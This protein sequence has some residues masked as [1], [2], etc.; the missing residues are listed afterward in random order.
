[1]I[2]TLDQQIEAMAND[3]PNLAMVRRSPSG[4]SCIWKGSIRPFRKTY[5]LEVFYHAPI[6]PEVFTISGCQLLVQVR[7]PTLERHPDYDEGPI[8]HI[9]ANDE[10]PAYPYL[11]LFDPFKPEWTP[12][13]LISATTIPWAERWL[14]NYE[15]WLATKLWKGGGRHMSTDDVKKALKPSEASQQIKGAA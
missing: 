1:M 8:P 7:R 10:E 12:D 6:A 3:Y 11:C 2:K 5:D 9:Y 15:F 14:L 13:D 4:R